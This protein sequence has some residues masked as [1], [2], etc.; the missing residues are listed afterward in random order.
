M[1][2]KFGHISAL[3]VIFSSIAGCSGFRTTKVSSFIAKQQRIQ[4]FSTSSTAL[5]NTADSEPQTSRDQ[6]ADRIDSVKAAAIAAVG[7]S[8]I[9]LPFAGIK[10]A[11][12]SFDAQWEFNTDMLALS[13]AL[14]G[15]TYRYAIRKDENPNLKQGVV[16]AFAI[17]RTVSNIHVP[18]DQCSSLPLDCGPPFHYFNW[19]MITQGGDGFI[20]SL[21]AF[22]AAAFV[23][24]RSFSRGWLSKFP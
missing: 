11:L 21:I 1:Y 20:E 17:T 4:P 13:L 18:T 2:F 8:F 9:Y 16:G 22:G 24:E 6:F 10:G 15:I 14:F 19:D 23:L 12:N 3:L 5:T 7:G